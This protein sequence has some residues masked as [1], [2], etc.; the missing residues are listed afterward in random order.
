MCASLIERSN[1]TCRGRSFAAFCYMFSLV[2]NISLLRQ[3]NIIYEGTTISLN[4]LLCGEREYTIKE[5]GVFS[6]SL[7]TQVQKQLINVTNNRFNY[8]LLS[9]VPEVREAASLL[10]HG[11]LFCFHYKS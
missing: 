5:Y 11:A 7:W 2:P 9:V 3:Q 8:K 10:R 6:T 1:S 4:I